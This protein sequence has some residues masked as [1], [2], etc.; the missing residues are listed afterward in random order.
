MSFESQSFENSSPDAGSL[1]KKAQNLTE[2]EIEEDDDLDIPTEEVEKFF[3]K[4]V[5]TKGD[6]YV[7][8]GKNEK[9]KTA[10]RHIPKRGMTDD[11]IKADIKKFAI[12]TLSADQSI[13]DLLEEDTSYLP[14][15][16]E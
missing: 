5:Q 13:D 15:Q 8:R 16:E 2:T 14:E 7:L 1:S 10:N 12:Q 11:E 3:K 9:G 6:Y 4:C